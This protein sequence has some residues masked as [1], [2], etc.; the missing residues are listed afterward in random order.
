MVCYTDFESVE[1]RVDKILTQYRESPKLLHLI[2]TYLRQ[3]EV[4]HQSLCA[5]PEAFDL[6]TAVGDQLSILGRRMGFPREH[7]VCTT[8]PAFGFDCNGADPLSVDGFC[9]EVTWVDCD[10]SGLAFVTIVEDEL[11]RKFLKVRRYQMTGRF[12]RPS[13]EASIKTFWGEQSKILDSGHGQVVIGIGRPLTASELAIVQ[14][15]P[16]VLPTPLGVR[17][18]FHFGSMLVFGFGAGWG[19]FCDGFAEQGDQ[20]TTESLNPILIE[21]GSLLT[22]DA[23]G[24]GADWLC[25][26]DVRA[27]DC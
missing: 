24:I 3:V 21:D 10:T 14:L 2:R 7:C 25:P 15:Y 26:L 9:S 17:I 1:A 18:R 16:R 19:G 5:L 13:L 8:Q 22:A 11:Y 27:Y 23:L 4:I 20:L 12:D 6:E